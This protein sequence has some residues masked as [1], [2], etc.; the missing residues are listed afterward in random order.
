[1]HIVE[2][3]HD[4][5][6]VR[7]FMK[8]R[9]QLARHPVL[10]DRGRRRCRM[11]GRGV[12]RRQRR[13]PLIPRR[14]EQLHHARRRF[15][16]V[17]AQQRLERFEPRQVRISACQPFR[18]SATRDAAWPICEVVEEVFDERGLA[19]AGLAPHAHEQS[20]T[21]GG[22]VEGREQLGPFLFA[23]DT[24]S[25]RRGCQATG[26]LRAPRPEDFRQRRVDLGRARPQARVFLEHLQNQRVER[27]RDFRIEP[28][29]RLR[30]FR[31]DRVQHADLRIAG[32]R[33][34]TSGQLVEHDPE[35]KHVGR[36]RHRFAARLF[37]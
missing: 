7:D 25:S 9:G 14:R 33:T 35:R 30:M 13:H 29:R 28:R 17:A 15:A 18:A 1:M 20:V 31:Q 22:G 19:D 8:E 26:V 10:R 5:T 24:M 23:A 32:E 21:A 16:A 12:G 37:G 3:Q 2:E 27:S 11:A 4:R 6:K 34:Q 36:G